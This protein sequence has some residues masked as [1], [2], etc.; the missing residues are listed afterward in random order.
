MPDFEDLRL[1]DLVQKFERTISE[2]NTTHSLGKIKDAGRELQSVYDF[3]V[4]AE[5]AFEPQQE[6]FKNLVSSFNYAAVIINNAMKSGGLTREDNQLLNECF[7]VMLK[8]CTVI[9][10][11]L[12]K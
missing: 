7:E 2:I 6:Q 5:S 3:F 9:I 10:T 1:I 4:T 8:C 11:S 12:K